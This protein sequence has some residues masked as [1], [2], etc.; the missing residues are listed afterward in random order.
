MMLMNWEIKKNVKLD[1]NCHSWLSWIWIETYI[2]IDLEN[3]TQILKTAD[4][5]RNC[6]S[7]RCISDVTN[8]R[9]V[10]C[11]VHTEA[12]YT[13]YSTYVLIINSCEFTL[14]TSVLHLLYCVD[15]RV[16]TQTPNSK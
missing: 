7:I 10:F 16:N 1:V 2:Q 15:S 4:P 3:I 14:A 6:I 9:A 11:S 8:K 13:V 5:I 12:V